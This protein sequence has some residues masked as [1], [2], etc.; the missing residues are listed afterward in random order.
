ML[1]KQ[2]EKQK[3]KK[4]SLFCCFSSNKS[5]KKRKE[6]NNSHNNRSNTNK[7]NISE[8]NIN[9]K[10]NNFSIEDKKFVMKNLNNQNINN[11]K[12]SLNSNKKEDTKK[13]EKTKEK[14]KE[15]EKV[16][17]I[18]NDEVN[19]L[20]KS[21]TLEG[22]ISNKEENE[23]KNK[24]LKLSSF[25]AN[26]NNGNKKERYINICPIDKNYEKNKNYFLE[27]SDLIENNLFS[28]KEEEINEI[29]KENINII[30]ENLSLNSSDN[31]SI[32]K[33]KINHNE[34][35][36]IM[37]KIKQIPHLN[38]QDDDTVNIYGNSSF[39]RTNKLDEIKIKEKDILNNTF[40]IEL[41][42]NSIIKI[43]IK[44]EQKE[45]NN[46]RT[47]SFVFNKE[48]YNNDFNI[49]LNIEKHNKNSSICIDNSKIK[50]DLSKKIKDND[51]INDKN[52]NSLIE[53]KP[54]RIKKLNI[55]KISDKNIGPKNIPKKIKNCKSFNL[56]HYV[57]IEKLG[58]KIDYNN[59]TGS[60]SILNFENNK[61]EF[62]FKY[63]KK[64]NIT[65]FNNNFIN[66]DKEENTKIKI[67]KE[68]TV[69]AISHNDFN[70]NVNNDYNIINNEMIAIENENNLNYINKEK[71]FSNFS[72]KEINN[73]KTEEKFIIE[74]ADSK[75]EE[76]IKEINE[77]KDEK[78]DQDLNN[79]KSKLDEEKEKM[80]EEEEN[81]KDFEGEIEDE[82]DDLDEI[83]RKINDSK[84]IISNYIIAPLTGI[85]DLK[86]YAPSLC[87]KS[88]FKDNISNVNDLNS[89]KCG[90]FIIPFGINE[91]EIEIMNENGKEFKSFIE[92]PR[93]S[94][95]YN[96]RFTHKN[97]NYNNSNGNIKYSNNSSKS[98]NHKMKSICDKINS[99]TNEIQKYNEK[100]ILI[101]EKIKHYEEYNKKYELWIEK[102]EEES[103]F[104]INMLNFLN[105]QRK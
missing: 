104:L 63:K 28:N 77:N 44:K 26:I 11:S 32:N 19:Y 25:N 36:A 20:K 70:N 59:K 31:N 30:I 103:Q 46:N 15:K 56:L 41:N 14:I 82:Q 89:N 61:I 90:G 27:N 97:I 71:Y 74:N 94:G 99:N 81:I 83:S 50:L 42:K 48:N 37:E 73:T 18:N 67:D 105:N 8:Q 29:K 52:N 34:S 1:D 87:S 45:S 47:Y 51:D 43:T 64:S 101:D 79:V 75:S 7:T 91:T 68:K 38:N 66:T 95:T 72:N 86:S 55:I 4:F 3:K 80:K 78:K 39:N 35:L 84:S 2:N 57:K 65:Y 92:T 33:R 9:I 16:K 53:N 85:Q 13:S 93:A 12:I 5:A 49:N 69:S 40:N 17:I 60:Y 96:K 21:H 10:V 88:E 23:E 76:Q 22:I 6:K 58:K 24:I 54:E 102:E 100:I 98:M 62:N